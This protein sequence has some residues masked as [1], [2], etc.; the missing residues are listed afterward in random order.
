MSVPAIARCVIVR[1]VIG[2]CVLV[3]CTSQVVA[4]EHRLEHVVVTYEG[5]SERY[6]EAIARTV[7][8][9]RDV[10]ASEYSFDMPATIRVKVTVTPRQRP[11]LFNDGVDTFSLSVRSERTC[12]S[13]ARAA[14][15]T[16]MVCATK[17]RTWRCTG[18]FE[19]TVG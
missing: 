11:R 6:A 8:A 16:C 7:A 3:V 5:I 19:I 4:A 14:C 9:A 13:R 18:P 17:S 15:F 1:C 12:D 2:L 10:C